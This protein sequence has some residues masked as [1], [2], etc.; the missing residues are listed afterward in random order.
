MTNRT[1]KIALY[2]AGAATLAVSVTTASFAQFQRS[3]PRQTQPSANPLGDLIGMIANASAQSKAK[4]GWAQV[5]P[6]I[7][8]CVNTIFA[9]RNLNVDQIIAA[10]MSPTHKDIV[11]VIELCQTVMT[12]QLRTNFP[13]NVT[14]S[15]GQQVATTCSQSYAKEVNGR[16]ASVSRDDFLRAA[17]NEEKVTI[18]DFE[19]TAA[20]NARLAEERRVIQGVPRPSQ[21]SA[22]GGGSA[23]AQRGVISGAG[24]RRHFIEW[25]KGPKNVEVPG[26]FRFSGNYIIY[27]GQTLSHATYMGPA[28]KAADGIF[29]VPML[30]IV[31]PPDV[32][33]VELWDR[34]KDI[35]IKD[36]AGSY[37]DVWVINC[38]TGKRFTNQ[39]MYFRGDIKNLDLI[40][41]YNNSDKAV[42]MHVSFRYLDSLFT[43]EIPLNDGRE[44]EFDDLCIQ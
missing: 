41:S 28:K 25:F 44:S 19:T 18:G 2:A 40:A 7:H 27:G 8:Q 23:S 34:Q 9:T 5:A 15:K 37:I 36:F 24:S 11:P 30:H 16:W 35:L 6:E 22:I 14:N 10:G 4:K 31:T 1:L 26:P 29:L 39:R 13:C 32:Y 17:A 21:G 38:R 12:A 43:S 42:K 20:Q 3:Q 33:K